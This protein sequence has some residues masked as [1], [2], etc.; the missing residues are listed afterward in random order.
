MSFQAEA[1]I[2]KFKAGSEMILTVRLRDISQRM[3]AEQGL[4][5]LAAI[6][7]SSED[8]IISQS[9]DGVITTWNSGAEK[10]FGY[11][12]A[13][14]IGLNASILLP[15]KLREELL[16][17]VEQVKQGASWK[18]ETVRVRKDGRHIDVGL[19]MSLLKGEKGTGPGLSM[20]ARDITERKR[21]E[22]QLR[23]SQKMEAVGRLA[24][25]VAHD[26]NNLLSVI[27][28][29]GYLIH[30]NTTPIIRRMRR[31]RKL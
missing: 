21:L 4:R 10:M 23:Q 2:A 20:I 16:Q 31:R 7:D 15:P 8:A 5:Q 19:S 3:Q 28:G 1:S 17:Q 24:G 29:Y 26:F 12:A 25:G 14:I 18:G 27:V 6:V 9:M 13:E 11:A 22:E 30:A